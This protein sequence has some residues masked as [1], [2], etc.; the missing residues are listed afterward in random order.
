VPFLYEPIDSSQ[1][2]PLP[3][4]PPMGSQFYRPTAGNYHPT[5]SSP[6]HLSSLSSYPI[7]RPTPVPPSMS[8]HH[9]NSLSS[10]P[11]VAIIESS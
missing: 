7:N 11:S 5:S 9:Y 4:N 1:K 6:T 8:N 10:S 2:D 3:Y